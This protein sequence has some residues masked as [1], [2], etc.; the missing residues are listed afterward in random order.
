[1]T[2]S[3][4]STVKDFTKDL[5]LVYPEYSR[6]WSKWQDASEEEFTKLHAYCAK[7]YPE[8]F[9]DIMNSNNAIFAAD[10]TVNVN[11]LPGV[12][13]KTLYNCEGVSETTKQ[14]IWKYLQLILFFVVGS[15]KDNANFGEAMGMFE[16]MNEEELQGKMA[17]T[18]ASIEEFFKEK[19]E[20]NTSESQTGNNNNDDEPSSEPFKMPDLAEL[21]EHMKGL[22]DGK[23]GK[24]AKEFTDEFMEEMTD[25]FGDINKD[26]TASAKDIV[27]Q[28]MKNPQKM[29]IIFKRLAAKLQDKMKNGEINQE[30]LMQEL[31]GI[32][33]KMQKMGMGKGDMASL[34]AG[35][36]D[37]P[38]M[39]IF[40]KMMGKN[41][42]VD[43]NALARMNAQN[44]TKERLR[45]KL[46]QRQQQQQQ[47]QQQNITVESAGTN[48]Y[49]VHIGE[50]KQ[51]KS[52]IP[53]KKSKKTKK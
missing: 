22:L 39:K 10:A 2:E 48:H 13:F 34:L 16:S 47:Q 7:I 8:R 21:N 32:M 42:K 25:F 17:E 4:Q 38:F 14:S 50:E 9:F 40:E 37:M 46:E 31:N 5:S 45:K 26:D 35:M 52:V 6:F 33:E 12:D 36:K 44:A 51:Q 15:L 30:E 1:M 43:T 27:A 49:V 11:F 41:A 20:T 28:L 53:Q 29:M 3:F 19:Q 24:L 18:L 23:I